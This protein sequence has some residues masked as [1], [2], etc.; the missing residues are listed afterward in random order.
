MKRFKKIF[1]VLAAVVLAGY[2]SFAQKE[3]VVA[4]VVAQ[5]GS[6]HFQHIQDAVNS[7][8]ADAK[9]QRVI[10]I[11]QGTYKEKLF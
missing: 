3:I 9:T 10:L 8:P 11:K 2:S 6:G 7:L 5:D 4:I 1:L